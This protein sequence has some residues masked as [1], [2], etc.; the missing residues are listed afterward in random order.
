MKASPSLII[1]CAFLG[2]G[3][4]VL[5]IILL[6]QWQPGDSSSE[7]PAGVGAVAVSKNSNSVSPQ[8]NEEFPSATQ[9]IAAT[10]GPTTKPVSTQSNTAESSTIT[11]QSKSL[12]KVITDVQSGQYAV[13]DSSRRYVTLKDKNGNVIW[14]VDVVK[15]VE[16]MPSVGERKIYSMR[17]RGD[18][19][20]VTVGKDLLGVNKRSGKITYYGA[21]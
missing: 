17:L 18:E 5:L 10:T 19:L 15:P 6:V 9:T 16:T 14:S 20:I 3:I 4:V 21:N 7:N 11:N 13:V 12:F 2:G 1:K 8:T